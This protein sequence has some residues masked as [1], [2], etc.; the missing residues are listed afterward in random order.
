MSEE[1]EK[2]LRLMK[3]WLIGTFVIILGAMIALGFVIP[4]LMRESN[5]WWGIAVAALACGG[6]YYLYKAW[7]NR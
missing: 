3:F 7:V 2:T 5:F 1:K 6:W 4:G